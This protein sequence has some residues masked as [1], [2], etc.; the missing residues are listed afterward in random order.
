MRL[1]RL[2]WPQRHFASLGLEGAACCKFKVVN[3]ALSAFW[4]V[5]RRANA[6]AV[7]IGEP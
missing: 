3:R 5:R 1:V 4:G 2:T 6:R 7:A